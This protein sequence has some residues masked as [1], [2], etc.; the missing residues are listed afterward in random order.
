MSHVST[1]QGT[2]ED[3]EVV[4]TFG[5]G[6]IEAMVGTDVVQVGSISATLKNSVLLMVDQALDF[7]DTFN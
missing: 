4:L 6:Q 5:S 1:R 3:E 2:P 7:T